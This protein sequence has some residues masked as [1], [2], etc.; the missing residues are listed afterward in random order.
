MKVTAITSVDE[1]AVDRGVLGRT[2]ATHTDT[3]DIY[4]LIQEH[5]SVLF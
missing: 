5:L 3:Q 4:Y 2:A 1:I